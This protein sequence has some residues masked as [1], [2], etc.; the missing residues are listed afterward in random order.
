MSATLSPIPDASPPAKPPEWA[1]GR[2]VI[3]RVSSALAEI[4][5]LQ[6]EP[7]YRS[8]RTTCPDGQFWLV[9]RGEQ[10]VERSRVGGKQRPFELL[11]YAPREGAVRIAETPSLAYGLRI[12]LSA[13]RS[14]EFDSSWNHGFRGRIGEEQAVLRVV[15]GGLADPL[16]IDESVADLLSGS[17]APTPERRATRWLRTMREIIENDPQCSLL[18]M[19][20][21]IGVAPAYA[22]AQFSRVFG[23]TMT[24]YRRKVMISKALRMASH[25]TLN[26]AAIEAGFYD[27]SH[28]HRAC[29]SQLGITP[30]HLRELMRET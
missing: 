9:A 28:F 23:I 22:S 14:D 10:T 6:M 27:A 7:G 18:E 11:Y 12:R 19:S 20:R 17:P 21:S 29:T 16:G 25:S 4:V 3:R 24:G 26:E 2:R 5:V 15:A 1:N 8:L 13:M 30:A